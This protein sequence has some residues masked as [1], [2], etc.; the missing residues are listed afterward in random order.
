MNGTLNKH[1]AEIDITA[2]E[3]INRIIKKMAEQDNIRN[4]NLTSFARAKDRMIATND[5]AYR[6]IR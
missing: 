5:N 2:T 6:G 1:L 4:F 3:R